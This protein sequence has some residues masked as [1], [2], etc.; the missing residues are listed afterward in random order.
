LIVETTRVGLDSIRPYASGEIFPLED[1]VVR[2]YPEIVAGTPLA[3]SLEDGRPLTAEEAGRIVGSSDHPLKMSYGASTTLLADQLYDLDSI[4]TQ[5]IDNEFLRSKIPSCNPRIDPTKIDRT[6]LFSNFVA[7]DRKLRKSLI[8]HYL[9]DLQY[10]DNQIMPQWKLPEFLATYDDLAGSL[11]AAGSDATGFIQVDAETSVPLRSLQSHGR[12]LQELRGDAIAAKDRYLG[13]GRQECAGRAVLDDRLLG[14]LF[15]AP[16]G[17]GLYFLPAPDEHLSWSR[18][19]VE[20]VGDCLAVPAEGE[21]V[22]LAALEHQ[23]T[24]RE[25]SFRKELYERVRLRGLGPQVAEHPLE[26]TTAALADVL[27]GTEKNAKAVKILARRQSPEST[28][29]EPSVGETLAELGRSGINGGLVWDIADFLG[30]EKMTSL[31]L[32]YGGRG[33]LQLTI[34]RAQQLAA[35]LA[36]TLGARPAMELLAGLA[37]KAADKN[38]RLSAV[39]HLGKLQGRPAA[40][41]SRLALGYL[42]ESEPYRAETLVA[43]LQYGLLA[44]DALSFVRKRVDLLLARLPNLD[45]RRGAAD[46]EQRLFSE[47]VQV[48]LTLRNLPD[49]GIRQA[50]HGGLSNSLL[51]DFKSKAVGT[52]VQVQ[53]DWGLLFNKLLV[54]ALLHGED[55]KEQQTERLS[56]AWLQQYIRFA[57]DRPIGKLMLDPVLK[58]AGDEGLAALLAS[59]I[60]GQLARLDTLRPPGSQQARALSEVKA[61]LGDGNVIVRMLLAADAAL[62]ARLSELPAEQFAK[63]S[64][65]K[66]VWY[67]EKLHRRIVPIIGDAGLGTSAAE[68]SAGGQLPKASSK[69]DPLVEFYVDDRVRESFAMLGYLQEGGRNGNG[70]KFMRTQDLAAIKDPS[71][72]RVV[73]EERKI[74]RQDMSML[75]LALNPGNRPSAIRRVWE[76]TLAVTDKHLGISLLDQGLRRYLF[77]PH[78]PY[79]TENESGFFFSPETIE[80]LHNAALWGGRND[81]LLSSYLHFRHLPGQLPDWLRRT[82]MARSELELQIIKKFEQQSFLPMILQCDSDKSELP[83][84]LFRAKW[85]IRKPFGEDIFPGTLLLLRLGYLEVTAAG[86]IVRTA[87]YAGG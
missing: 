50:L 67:L 14:F 12:L 56:L 58:I 43:L 77:A 57:A 17:P 74:T 13:T 41:I 33:D 39:M 49:Q 68:T 76:E 5:R 30:P 55:G 82:A 23:T 27:A 1:F 59:V 37:E 86:E 69:T 72:L 81:I 10:W 47:L 51:S 9:A 29:G 21:H 71:T 80:D 32:Y 19:L 4:R 36:T 18:L 73:E 78:Y 7:I 44:E 38:L 8:S 87:K 46:V 42:Q 28:I 22:L 62:V 61:L 53:A 48:A 11:L 20:I 31:F 40:E 35:Q 66:G 16:E 45:D 75:T 6:N 24:G 60:P 2:Y 3:G 79:L 15:T 84:P 54:L 65:T 64:K 83:E 26:A 25:T 70:V 85:A 34:H 63:N 52:G